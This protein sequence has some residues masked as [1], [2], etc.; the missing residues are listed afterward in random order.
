MPRSQANLCLQRHRRLACK[1]VPLLFNSKLTQGT[2]PNTRNVYLAGYTNKKVK[3]VAVLGGGITGLA[4]AF[5]ISKRAP[6]IP[7]T[8]YEAGPRLGGWLTSKHIRTPDGRILFQGGPKTIR[9]SGVSFLSTIQMIRQLDLVNELEII[10]QRSRASNKFL[11][12]P[13]RLVL[14]PNSLSSYLGTPNRRV[15]FEGLLQGLIMEPFRKTRPESLSDESISSF[16]SRRFHPK[17]AQNLASAFIHGIYGGDIDRLSVKSIFPYLWA[18]EKYFGSIFNGAIQLAIRGRTI[19]NPR[20]DLLSVLLSENDFL[21]STLQ[22]QRAMMISFNKG[23]EAL[24]LA[25][26]RY[27]ERL[28]NVHIK[29]NAPVKLIKKREEPSKPLEILTTNNLPTN[30]FSHVISALPAPLTSSILPMPIAPLSTVEAV[31]VQVV[32]LFFPS[33]NIL[34][35]RGFGYLI[36]KSVSPEHNPEQALGVIFDSECQ[37]K[38]IDGEPFAPGTTLSQEAVANALSLV[39]RHLGIVDEATH[40]MVSTQKNCIP[41]FTV[42][43]DDRMDFAHELLKIQFSG[44]LA[45]AGPYRGVGIN[46][47]IRSAY[48]TVIDMFRAGGP[49]GPAEED[50]TGLHACG[51]YEPY[52]IAR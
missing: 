10:T 46:D 8:I 40:Y 22:T 20:D 35:V 25:L 38:M 43:H 24:P 12:Y 45:V 15:V 52:I 11:Y 31:T 30:S 32:N 21:L 5:Y 13:D 26:A 49:L 2:T 19:I 50:W 7:I 16:L 1:C 34:P 14:L 33:R 28:P 48:E 18:S 6:G 9:T 36:S 41:Q 39:R 42:G 29:L 3:S 37:P 23:M 17:F 27:F 44:R 51:S 4:T 47:C